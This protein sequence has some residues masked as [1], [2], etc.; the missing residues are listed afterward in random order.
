MAAQP[1]PRSAG[2][3][4]AGADDGDVA[5]STGRTLDRTL[6]DVPF[7]PPTIADDIPVKPLGLA[8]PTAI[9][10]AAPARAA[11]PDLSVAV[12]RMASFAAPAVRPGMGPPAPAPGAHPPLTGLAGLP[13]GMMT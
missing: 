10:P 3:W 6:G 11:G 12:E 13:T 1:G 9:A 2:A 4:D 7:P 8:G 5:A